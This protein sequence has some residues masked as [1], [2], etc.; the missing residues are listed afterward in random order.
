MVSIDEW[1]SIENWCNDND[2]GNSQYQEKSLSQSHFVRTAT[3]TRLR[4]N[5]GLRDDRPAIDRL[6]PRTVAQA[7]QY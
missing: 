6:N 4:L 2:K 5:P 3:Q 1:M 7:L